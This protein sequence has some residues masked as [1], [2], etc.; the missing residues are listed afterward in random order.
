MTRALTKA[1]ENSKGSANPAHPLR[2]NPGERTAWAPPGGALRTNPGERAARGTP[3]WASWGPGRPLAWVIAWPLA[4][5]GLLGGLTLLG[6]QEWTGPVA[7]VVIAAQ[8]VDGAIL[9][10]R[11]QAQDLAQRLAAAHRKW[12]PPPEDYLQ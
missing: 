9:R 7:M 10:P 5:L 6:W 2:T 12:T 3:A 8:V 1:G 11:R 4:L